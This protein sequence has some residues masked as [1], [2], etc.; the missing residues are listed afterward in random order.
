MGD[1]RL[2]ESFLVSVDSFS[3]AEVRFD[4]GKR[5]MVVVC[6]RPFNEAER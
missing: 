5:W 1:L 6:L 4:V 2:M 3:F